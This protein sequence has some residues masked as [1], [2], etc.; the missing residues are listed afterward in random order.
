MSPKPSST[1]SCIRS[2]SATDSSVARVAAHAADSLPSFFFSPQPLERFGFIVEP[3][4]GEAILARVALD[5]S[6]PDEEEQARAARS[7]QRRH[8]LVFISHVVLA[9]LGWVLT[10]AYGLRG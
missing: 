8:A 10:S 7:L 3:A 9:E 2:K 6:P 5:W 4:H 1:R